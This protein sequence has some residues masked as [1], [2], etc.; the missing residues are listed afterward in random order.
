MDEIL[1]F[2]F[3]NYL[4]LGWKDIDFRVLVNGDRELLRGVSGETE[5]ERKRAEEE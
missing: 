4:R 5:S 1:L 2:L 3:D